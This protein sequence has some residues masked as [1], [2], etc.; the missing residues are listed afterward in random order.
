MAGL[1]FCSCSAEFRA[2]EIAGGCIL[3]WP[4]RPLPQASG[5]K[6]EPAGRPG[7]TWLSLPRGP[8][9]GS[10]S[11]TASMGLCGKPHSGGSSLLFVLQS[12]L[13]WKKD[14]LNSG[15]QSFL[16]LMGRR[17][18]AGSQGLCCSFQALLP[19]QYPVPAC[20]HSSLLPIPSSVPP[21]FLAFSEDS[22]DWETQ[23]QLLITCKREA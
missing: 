22:E 8:W 20:R 13:T 11:H 12:T 2:M 1:L 3:L 5:C 7:A 14:C 18:Q 21:F 4:G 16:C 6:P 10:G 19:D 9:A 15:F 23:T 17:V